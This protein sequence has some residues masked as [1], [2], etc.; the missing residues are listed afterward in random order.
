MGATETN[1][2]KWHITNYTPDDKVSNNRTPK[3]KLLQ[4]GSAE[5]YKSESGT[6]ISFETVERPRCEDYKI[7]PGSGIKI[8]YTAKDKLHSLE[9]LQKNKTKQKQIP[10]DL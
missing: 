4:G 6:E 5:W 1:S 3:K 2:T 8:Y 10:L 7:L 9:F